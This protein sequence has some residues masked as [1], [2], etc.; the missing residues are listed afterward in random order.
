[1]QDY[2]LVRIFLN[3]DKTKVY[4]KD[5]THEEP[6]AKLD[7]FQTPVISNKLSVTACFVSG[8]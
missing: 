5:T 4:Q 6:A 8:F 3:A 1:M 7:N 2:R